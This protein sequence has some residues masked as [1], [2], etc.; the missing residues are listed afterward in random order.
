MV[1]IVCGMLCP[2]FVAK[3]LKLSLVRNAIL[4]LFN[5]CLGPKHF[6]RKH[7]E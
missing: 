6:K 5:Q 2:C 4:D 3:M 7:S 1:L